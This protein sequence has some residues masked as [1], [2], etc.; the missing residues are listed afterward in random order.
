VFLVHGE[1]KAVAREVHKARFLTNLLARAE[2][3]WLAF[4]EVSEPMAN[5]CER[6]SVDA[7]PDF[8]RK[9]V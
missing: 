9:P 8:R 4:T 6:V 2:Q 3:R 5:I 7:V 1:S